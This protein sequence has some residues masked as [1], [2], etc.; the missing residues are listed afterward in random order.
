MQ[1]WVKES[2]C[3]VSRLYC[4]PSARIVSYQ[5][6]GNTFYY[7]LMCTTVFMEMN[8]RKVKIEALK[9]VPYSQGTLH[10]FGQ[11]CSFEDIFS[12]PEK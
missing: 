8:I 2:L 5:F 7:D 12:L 6:W 3:S 10:K 9:S 1:Y 11:G 4:I